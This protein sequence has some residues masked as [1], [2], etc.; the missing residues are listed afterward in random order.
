MTTGSSPAGS[1]RAA[2]S[3]S[4]ALGPISA[5]GPRAVFIYSSAPTIART[6]ERALE[7]GAAGVTASAT[8]LMQMLGRIGLA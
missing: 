4:S 5:A 1:S 2:S 8:E 3:R 7:A 6:R